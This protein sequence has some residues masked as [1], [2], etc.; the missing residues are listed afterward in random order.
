MRPRE[1]KLHTQGHTAGWSQR[2]GWNPFLLTFRLRYGRLIRGSKP[3]NNL[4][5]TCHFETMFPCSWLPSTP[6]SVSLS[7]I[8][9]LKLIAQ[10]ILCLLLAFSLS[11]FFP[12]LYSNSYVYCCFFIVGKYF[13]NLLKIQRRSLSKALPNAKD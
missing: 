10:T 12:Q 7:S 1:A 2:Q 13:M 9:W 5:K 4:W 11:F 6:S 3:Y 8:F